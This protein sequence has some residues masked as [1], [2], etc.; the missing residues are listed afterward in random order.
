MVQDHFWKNAFFTHFLRI[1]GPKTH[2]GKQ[3]RPMA[4]GG[5]LSVPRGHHGRYV[6][7]KW[8]RMILGSSREQP[9]K[10]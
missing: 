1:V 2:T 7:G 8:T 4:H 5:R 9:T 10:N 3:R 6:N